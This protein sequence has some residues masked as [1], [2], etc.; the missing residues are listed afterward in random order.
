[1]SEKI[2]KKE[3]LKKSKTSNYNDEVLEILESSKSNVG[4]EL[5]FDFE[6]GSFKEVDE[7][8][9]MIDRSF[10][11]PEEKYNL[12]YN[13]TQKLINKYISD[14]R[15]RK[16]VNGEKLIFLNRGK[17][18]GKDGRRGSDSRMTY[19]E[20]ISEIAQIV[21]EWVMT[22]R[23]PTKLYKRF[24]DLNEKYGYPHQEL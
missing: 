7:I 22:S 14:T 24:Y 8:K 4:V 2:E 10:E 19:N 12:F 15:V 21:S 1:M 16:I 5:T 11:D 20:D 17:V 3:I 6:K 9:E 18:I 23:D 13:G